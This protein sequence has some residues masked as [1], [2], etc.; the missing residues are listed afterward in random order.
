MS[1]PLFG[2]NLNGVDRS[3]TVWS[4][5]TCV[6]KPLVSGFDSGEGRLRMVG[7]NGCLKDPSPATDLD[8]IMAFQGWEL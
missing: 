1:L 8:G 5:C 4:T 7:S 6:T 2:G 3:V